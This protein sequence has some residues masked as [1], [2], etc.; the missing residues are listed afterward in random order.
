V[1]PEV[2]AESREKSICAAAAAATER[3]Y[4]N[5]QGY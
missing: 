5:R 2:V 4:Q 3:K 1:R